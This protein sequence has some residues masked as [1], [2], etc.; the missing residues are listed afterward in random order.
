LF[1]SKR[2]KYLNSSTGFY[3][4][5]TALFLELVVK[6]ILGYQECFWGWNDNI[7]ILVSRYVIK[8][9]FFTVLIILF[10]FNIKEIL[11]NDRK[12][13]MVLGAMILFIIFIILRITENYDNP[14]LKEYNLT[15]LYLIGD[16]GYFYLIGL[17]LSSKQG[18]INRMKAP[19]ITGQILMTLQVLLFFNLSELSV[20]LKNL[21]HNSYIHLLIGGNY[22]LWSLLTI[23][24]FPKDKR[25][26]GFALCI[27][28]LF[29]LSSRSA[30]YC[31]ILVAPL[32][33]YHARRSWTTIGL[34]LAG[35]LTAVLIIFPGIFESHRMLAVL[36]F[37]DLSL[38]MRIETLYFAW[39]DIMNNFIS[40]CFGCFLRYPPPSNTY[41]HSILSV[42]SELGLLPFLLVTFLFILVT[43][44]IKRFWRFSKDSTVF[45]IVSF[46]MYFIFLMIFS[47][48]YSYPLFFIIFGFISNRVA[49]QLT[50][51][52]PNI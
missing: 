37:N 22:A 3:V 21:H 17:F 8:V 26:L 2:F 24:L 9:P 44:E 13:M 31:F 36:S 10:T 4:A 19:V 46:S 52:G 29:F 18:M 33:L 34:I 49:G 51:T 14:D 27:P 45:M 7:N 38:N 40:G 16:F 25:L 11:V 43:L 42:W 48:S 47:R 1:F 50:S 32:L 20:E 28:F 5:F 15:H 23:S 30:L 6:S 41:I 39:P 12:R 35:V